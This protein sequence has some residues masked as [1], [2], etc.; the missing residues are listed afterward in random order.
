[1]FVIYF[2]MFTVWC[3]S[4]IVDDGCLSTTGNN[5]SKCSVGKNTILS[6]T[7]DTSAT[8]SSDVPILNSG[9]SGHRS[10]T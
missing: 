2:S 8:E 5:V 1:M 7:G 6:K 10:V 9:S 3:N 4:V